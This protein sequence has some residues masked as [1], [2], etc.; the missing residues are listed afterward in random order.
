M[1]GRIQKRVV[2]V[3]TVEL[4][5]LNRE[6][7]QGGSRRQ[8]TVD[9]GAASALR[10]ELAADHDLFPAVFEDCLDRRS[11]FA[12]ADEVSCRAST[13]Q[14]PDGFDEDGL[15]GTGFASEDVEAGL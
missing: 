11:F 2:L 8:S 12:S 7:L 6:V 13:E 4:D 9:E 5:Q 14:Q 3:L 15:A 1:R 10:A